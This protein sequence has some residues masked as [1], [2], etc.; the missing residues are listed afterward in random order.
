MNLIKKSL[1][2]RKFGMKKMTPMSSA[3]VVRLI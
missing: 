3:H 1:D 2:V